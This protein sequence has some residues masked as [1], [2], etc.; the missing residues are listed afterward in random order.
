MRGVRT[1]AFASIQ[2]LPKLKR[3]RPTALW[4]YGGVTVLCVAVLITA[5]AQGHGDAL[6]TPK[7][8]SDTSA[9]SDI[10]VFSLLQR[11]FSVGE[12][13]VAIPG[14]AKGLEN[15]G[16][17]DGV[18]IGLTSFDNPTVGSS[19]VRFSAEVVPDGVSA[20]VDHRLSDNS[21]SML[22]VRNPFCDRSSD[23]YNA[24]VKREEHFGPV[25]RSGWTSFTH[26]GNRRL[27]TYP[28]KAKSK[29]DAAGQSSFWGI[30]TQFDVLRLAGVGASDSD[31]FTV[32]EVSAGYRDLP[33]GSPDGYGVRLVIGIGFNT[34]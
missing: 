11:Q 9:Q 17:N 2:W 22:C 18:V 14:L 5:I 19:W 21:A 10:S 20:F 33:A 27:Y 6:P 15:S 16:R 7:A 3:P 24:F 30:G 25:E 26:L 4:R 34:R 13:M 28:N 8:R 32:G 31:F 23:P 29:D 12:A 1:M